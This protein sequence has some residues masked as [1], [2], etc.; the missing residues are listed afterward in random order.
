MTVYFLTLRGTSEKLKDPMSMFG[1]VSK[2]IGD[3]S[4]IDISYPASVGFANES[5][6]AFGDSLD[7][8]TKE[9]VE[10]LTQ[11]IKNLSTFD[12]TAKYVLGGYSLGSLVVNRWL[13]EVPLMLTSNIV[14]VV[15]IANPLRAEGDSFMRESYGTGITGQPVVQI[16]GL[17]TYNLAN[18]E[19]MIT[20]L[21]K[22]SPLRNLVPWVYAMDLDNPR[23]WVESVIRQAQEKALWQAR[24]RFFDSEWYD[25]IARMP[26]D[27]Y[28]YALGGNH[29]LAYGEKKWDN[30]QS[31]VEIASMLVRT[32]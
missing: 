16:D 7:E 9:G 21:N 32:A 15:H 26:G 13:H 3:A 17:P 14:R 10:N 30:G 19:D 27:L 6:N 22:K 28:G 1:I 5:N 8:S 24:F 2:D 29:T 12:P 23:E 31:A 4:W 20:S 11:M 25:A 18:P